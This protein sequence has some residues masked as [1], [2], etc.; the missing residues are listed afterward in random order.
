MV[1]KLSGDIV[2]H[3]PPT[4]II[5]KEFYSVLKTERLKKN[6]IFKACKVT[7]IPYRIEF[8]AILTDGAC[9]DGCLTFQCRN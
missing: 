4:T 3:L 2:T 9:G 8:F 6:C 1:L 5:L 7:E